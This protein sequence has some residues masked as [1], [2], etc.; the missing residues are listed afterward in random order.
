METI[1][2]EEFKEIKERVRELYELFDKTEELKRGA[3]EK[4]IKGI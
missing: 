4:I 2:E 1:T 3:W